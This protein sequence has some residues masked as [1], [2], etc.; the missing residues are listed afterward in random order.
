MELERNT[1]TDTY[2]GMTHEAFEKSGSLMRIWGMPEPH[3]WGFGTIKAKALRRLLFV[4]T[5]E[6][7]D[8][9]SRAPKKH[10]YQRPPVEGR[11]PQIGRYYLQNQNRYLITPLLL[12]VRLSDPD[13]IEE[14]VRLFNG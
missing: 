10:G 12:S 11:F 1:D 2:D 5:Y 9:D 6:E 14:F 7:S 8:P 13:E 4:S 3:N